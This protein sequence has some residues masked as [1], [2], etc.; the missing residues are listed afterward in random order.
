VRRLRDAEAMRGRTCSGASARRAAVLLIE[1]VL[2]MA[3]SSDSRRDV[4]LAASGG[5]GTI[6]AV[7][8]I[9]RERRGCV[10]SCAGAT[11]QSTQTSRSRALL[12]SGEHQGA[13][14][15]ST[16]QVWAPPMLAFLTIDSDVARS[17]TNVHA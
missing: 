15:V 7:L 16:G 10:R 5:E 14:Q 11:R 9:A 17:R 3:S 13:T 2:T 6:E 1:G 4:G 8:V 12:K